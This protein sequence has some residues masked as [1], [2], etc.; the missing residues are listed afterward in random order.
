MNDVPFAFASRLWSTGRSRIAL[1]LALLTAAGVLAYWPALGGE[2]LWDDNANVTKPDLRSAF[3]LARIWFE[4]GATEQYYPVLHST[5]WLEHRIWGDHPLGYH[6][7]TLGFH[8]GAA[9]LLGLVLRRLRVPGGWLAAFVFALHPVAVESVAWIAEQKNTLSTFLYLASALAYL[10]FDENRRARSYAIA[11]G[12]FGLALL[13]KSVT[14]TLPAALLVVFWWQRGRIAWRSDVWPLVPW[15][16]LGAAVGIFSAWVERHYIGAEGVNFALSAAQRGLIAGRVVWFY[17]GKLLWPADLIFIYPRW[18]VDPAAAWQYVF[19]AATLAALVLLWRMR[20]WSRAP[21]AAALFFGGSLFPVL[22]FLNVYAFV[23]SFVTDHWQYLASIG[24][25]VL[26]SAAL[27][28]LQS[29]LPAA[30]R[31]TGAVPTIILLGSLGALTWRQSTNYR[32][33]P[34]FYRRILERNQ[35]CWM[36]HNNL[37]LLLERAQQPAAA[38]AHYETALRLRPDYAKAHFNLAS[39]LAESGRAAEAIGHYEAVLR[40]EPANA[41][42]HNNLGNALAESGR[43][44][45]AVR[46]FRAALA[47]GPESAETRANLGAVLEALG[48]TDEALQQLG[49]AVRVAPADPAI[50]RRFGACLLRSGRA[51][52]ALPQFEA[53]LRLQPDSAEAHNLAGVARAQLGQLSAAREDF[54]AALQLQPDHAGARENLARVEALLSNAARAGATPAK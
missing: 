5:F 46:H 48:R 9:F 52:E 15:F 54:A 39:A 44:V 51:A 3:G 47:A 42:A 16:A 14:A 21:L 28:R 20:R 49:I 11:T 10:R 25:I 34:T 37:G 13:S 43:L 8:L 45:E 31:V 26:F 32:D 30:G 29:Q 24:V 18:N 35:D 7:A 41:E 1:L 38:I 12:L 36:A 19:P 4:P 50:R 6:L 22:G 40:L 17:L 33:E 2:F 27:A 53:S 23:F